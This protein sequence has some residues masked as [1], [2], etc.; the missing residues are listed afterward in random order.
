[1]DTKPKSRKSSNSSEIVASNNDLLIE[2]LLKLPPKSFIKFTS[3][4]KHWLSLASDPNFCRRRFPFPGSITG[5]FRISYSV[6]SRYPEYNFVDLNQT[7]NNPPFRSLTF[8][9]HPSEIQIVQSCN[10]LLLCA[11]FE[12]RKTDYYVYNPTTNK[13]K[14]VPQVKL[15]SSHVFGFSLAFDPSKS[16]HYKAVCVWNR[17]HIV[18]DY[19]QIGVYS[20]EIG[21]WRLCGDRFYA[22]HSTGP[23]LLCIENENGFESGVFWNGA[24]HWTSL[25]TWSLLYFNVDEEKLSQISLPRLPEEWLSDINLRYFDE[26]RGHLHLINQTWN[27]TTLEL[28]VYEMEMDYSGWFVKFR[29]DCSGFPEVIPSNPLAYCRYFFCIL[30][31]VRGDVDEESYAVIKIPGKVIRYNFQTKA[32]HKLCDME[33]RDDGGYSAYQYIESLA[34]V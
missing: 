29:I 28:D 31:I 7:S 6:P 33:F 14:L 15:P 27:L 22:H 1:M 16:P 30:C 20:S 34:L 23:A 32:F 25:S 24:I 11:S 10:G 4:S 21:K 17:Y 3:V 13:Y 12:H 2:I 9:D 19:Y 5:L 26:S 18:G 8:F